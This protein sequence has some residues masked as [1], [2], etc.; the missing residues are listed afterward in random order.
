MFA[1]KK[2]YIL[3]WRQ[4][5]RKRKNYS[6]RAFTSPSGNQLSASRW[7]PRDRE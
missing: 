7:S 5:L 4:Q 3:G 2:K 6:A 1:N